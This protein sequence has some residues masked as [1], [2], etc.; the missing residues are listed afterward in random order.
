[1]LATTVQVEGSGVEWSG[2][3]EQNLT[4][5]A[6]LANAWRSAGIELGN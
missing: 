4:S 6:K 1:M 5:V 2:A 3:K